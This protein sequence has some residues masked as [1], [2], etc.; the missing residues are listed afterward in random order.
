[1]LSNHV[2]GYVQ[3]FYVTEFALLKWE[4]NALKGI[5]CMGRAEGEFKEW[6]QSP[7]QLPTNE[8]VPFN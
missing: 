6:G 7:L 4:F 3:K 2:Q 8:F 1:M 5:F